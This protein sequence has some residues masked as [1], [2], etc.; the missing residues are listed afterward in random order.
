MDVKEWLTENAKIKRNRFAVLLGLVLFPSVLLVGLY[1]LYRN[2]DNLETTLHHNVVVLSSKEVQV[3]NAHHAQTAFDRQMREWNDVLLHGNNAQDRQAYVNNFLREE[4]QVRN[5]IEAMRDAA[6]SEHDE[7]GVSNLQSVL[8]LHQDLGKRYRD[9]L[10]KLPST[11]GRSAASQSDH[12]VSGMER[13]LGAQLAQISDDIELEYK[14]L[15][16]RVVASQS[17]DIE[18][19]QARVELNL[20]AITLLI[21]IEALFI[22]RAVHKSTHDLNKLVD[23]S[24]KTVYHL[25]YSDSL[26]K[27]PNRRLFQDRLEHAIKQSNRSDKYRA[28][29]YLDMDNFKILNDSQGHGMGDLLLAEVAKR[30]LLCARESDT[31]A[32]LGGDEFVLLLGELSENETSATEQ[33]SMI[34]EKISRALSQ[35]Y[36]L[37]QL[38]YNTSASIGVTMFR[39]SGLTIEDV[40]KRADAAMYQA[41]NAGRNTVR[42]F[43]E[44]AQAAIE[45]RNE[46]EY[47]LKMAIAKQQ[48]QMHFQ[49]QVDHYSKPIGAEALIRWMHPQMGV[50]FPGQFIPLAE[51]TGLIL[52]IGQ[53]VLETVCEQIKRWES[54]PLTGNLQIAV[55]ISSRQFLQADFVTKVDEIIKRTGIRPSSLKLELTE[56]VVL[57]DVTVAVTKMHALKKLGVRLSMDDFGTGYSSLS[58]LTSLPLDQ[59]KI[60]QSFVRNIGIRS[61]DSVIAQTIIDMGNNL[62]ME[63]IAEGVETQAQ[64][65]F[66]EQAGCKLYQGYLY[67]KPVPPEKFTNA[68]LEMQVE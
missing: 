12:V 49:I 1:Q 47:A 44:H 62:N 53:W 9:A 16:A 59:L 13:S 27:L 10:A 34:A 28:L 24:E 45:A 32:R 8:D 19:V 35:P 18:D 2:I 26:T 51:E 30:L 36:Y 33:V 58:Y 21:L 22:L 57:S 54:N 56:S 25:A 6:L 31:V 64:R 41:K 61:A 7:S 42:F 15:S 39:N 50:I 66:L 23:E 65:A 60:D 11:Q 20:I 17:N 46:L 4:E 37:N 14:G 52:S 43:D 48:L 55:N 68:L 5:A 38:I 63:L 3:V 29:M 67:G 40:H